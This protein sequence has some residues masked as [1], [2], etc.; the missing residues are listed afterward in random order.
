MSARRES[1]TP[2][3]VLGLVP[4]FRTQV[5]PAIPTVVSIPKVPTFRK[6]DWNAA[7]LL[8]SFLIDI[9]TSFRPVRGQS[10]KKNHKNKIIPYWFYSLLNSYV[11]PTP[12]RY[13]FI[14][15][16]WG[17][18]PSVQLLSGIG[19]YAG[20]LPDCHT[21]AQAFLLRCHRVFVYFFCCKLCTFIFLTHLYRG[22]PGNHQLNLLYTLIHSPL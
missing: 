15:A 18:S 10:I 2:G 7:Q 14:L 12:S 6:I 17:N 11:K 3:I 1:L 13:I 19:N 8:C 22:F 20:A 21:C 16:Q 4:K 9:A 5:C